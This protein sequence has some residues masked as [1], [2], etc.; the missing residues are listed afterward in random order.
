MN[1][2]L[3][4]EVTEISAIFVFL[5]HFPFCR[6]FFTIKFPS[7]LFLSFSLLI[8]PFHSSTSPLVETTISVPTPPPFLPPN[9]L[10]TGWLVLLQKGHTFGNW[11]NPIYL[12]LTILQMLIFCISSIFFVKKAT[13]VG[14]S[15]VSAMVVFSRQ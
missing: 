1:R 9:E 4:Y 13:R 15:F 2:A 10:P 7:M 5:L 12:R 8:P 6:P 3:N 14:G 11:L